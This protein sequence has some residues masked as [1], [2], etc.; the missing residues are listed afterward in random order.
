MGLSVDARLID[1]R[2]D[3]EVDA[4]T[5]ATGDADAVARQSRSGVFGLAEYARDARASL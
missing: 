4:R 2:D 1:T 3:T 5:G